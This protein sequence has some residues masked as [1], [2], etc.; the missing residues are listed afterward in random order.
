MLTENCFMVKLAVRKKLLADQ[1]HSRKSL[2]LSVL[3]R[4]LAHD[5]CVRQHQQRFRGNRGV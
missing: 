1:R 4:F 3:I 5:W 2:R